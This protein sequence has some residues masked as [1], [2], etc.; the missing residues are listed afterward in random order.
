MHNPAT[1]TQT[2]KDFDAMRKSNSSSKPRSEGSVP[3]R[4]DAVSRE[5]PRANDS[6][7]V[8][9][10]PRHSTRS[11]RR[12]RSRSRSRSRDRSPEDRRKR[13]ASPQD[14]RNFVGFHDSGTDAASIDDRS[15]SPE[16]T[17]PVEKRRRLRLKSQQDW[18]D[19]DCPK[20][21]RVTKRYEPYVGKRLVTLP[22]DE[23]PSTKSTATSE[24]TRLPHDQDY[25]LSSSESYCG[26]NPTKQAP[27]QFDLKHYPKQCETKQFNIWNNLRTNDKPYAAHMDKYVGH[28]LRLELNELDYED[29]QQKLQSPDKD[30]MFFLEGIL[31]EHAFS[32][33][34][35]LWDES[36]PLAE[37]PRSIKYH[38]NEFIHEA[39]IRYQN[40]CTWYEKRRQL[41]IKKG[42][43]KRLYPLPW[44]YPRVFP[45]SIDEVQRL[46]I[47]QKTNPSL[48]GFGPYNDFLKN[49]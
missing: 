16:D 12:S 41:A 11:R 45:R 31:E 32:A 36:P 34:C 13:S 15:Q 44:S 49:N 30:R 6:Y 23:K 2:A 38:L 21:N 39:H 43:A 40:R 27:P 19:D 9:D 20:Y 18:P 28:Y 10:R 7:H 22:P 25:S 1:S 33:R 8:D 47:N 48:T 17:A 14:G 42:T 3:S 35:E 29:K 5:R 46:I 26:K 4:S 24:P 37:L